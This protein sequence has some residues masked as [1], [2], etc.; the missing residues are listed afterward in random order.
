MWEQL[1]VRI[2]SKTM[3]KSGEIALICALDFQM[4]HGS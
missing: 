2:D 4:A 1:L 3:S